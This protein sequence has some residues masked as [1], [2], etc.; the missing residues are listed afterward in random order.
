MS[1]FSLADISNP[2]HNYTGTLL[3]IAYIVAALEL[4]QHL[5][6]RLLFLHESRT[7]RLP[8]SQRP[9]PAHLLLFSSLAAL[10]FAVL[11]FHML[12]FL[13]AS[14]SAWCVANGFPRV[15]AMR[16]LMP[17]LWS[18]MT[19][20]ALFTTFARD[21]V[22][23]G[24]G[25]TAGW[26]EEEGG[27]VEVRREQ[28]QERGQQ[29]WVWTGMVVAGMMVG[30]Q[31]MARKGRGRGV[32]HLWA[33]FALGQI[34]PMSFTLNLFFITLLCLPKTEARKTEKGRETG[35]AGSSSPSAMLG[36]YGIGGLFMVVLYSLSNLQASRWFMDLFLFM[37]LLLFAP[38]LIHSV[39]GNG[40]WEFPLDPVWELMG[41]VFLGL[42]VVVLKLVLVD[43]QNVVEL[44]AAARSNPAARFLGFF[45][46]PE[47][48]AAP[49][50]LDSD[51]PADEDAF[52]GL[53]SG[54]I[55][56]FCGFGLERF[57]FCRA[58]RLSS[59]LWIEATLSGRS[60]VALLGRWIGPSNYCAAPIA[61]LIPLLHP[62]SLQ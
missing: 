14:Y 51:D 13:L 10:S 38:Y 44:V 49:G 59:V 1:S 41:G 53:L 12:S 46:W 61:S 45:F 11:S 60:S 27:W 32:S 4:S 8:A 28:E 2:P 19:E 20:S 47:A 6:T 29:V 22:G 15:F 55:V 25:G 17:R 37:R 9:S 40:G 56:V 62:L 5:T 23:V 57:W 34:L 18:W 39:A 52:F 48:D 16:E 35:S 7:S 31:W 54:L 43:G 50:L 24:A 42:W 36:A 26:R 58:R 30:G 21:L 3:F 33:Y